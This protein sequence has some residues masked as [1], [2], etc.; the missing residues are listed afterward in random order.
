M[1]NVN[2]DIK[3]SKEIKWSYSRLSC[4]KQCHFQYKLKYVDKHFP[5]FGNVA[6][7]FGTA[8]HHAE[9]T[10]GNFIKDNQ[11]IN[12]VQ[13]KNQFILDCA[14]TS[15]K[16]KEWFQQNKDSGKTYEEQKY[17]YLKYGVYRLE[18]FM[19]NHPT[20]IIK[21]AEVPIDYYYKDKRFT[22]S[23]DRLLFDTATG[24]Y[25][26]Q[27]IKSWP[28]M[29]PK[30]TED[31][32]LPVQLAVYSL[33]LSEMVGCDLDHIKCQY[34]LPL[35]DNIYDAGEP[36]FIDV[37]KEH[38]DEWFAGIEAQDWH[39]VATALCAWCP[40]SATNPDSSKDFKYLCP[41]HSVW[42]RE[43]KAKGTSNKP[44]NHW[45]GIENHESI[46]ENYLRKEVK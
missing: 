41:Y 7:E 10:I 22:G 14:K 40:F 30:H 5:P 29:E 25:Y 24:I 28:V 4:Y 45:A 6:T 43:L 16:Y 2:N 20:Y 33:A 37:T 38:L 26:I 1:Q 36:G 42:D 19:K 23:I 3:K 15:F 18:N 12:Y 39:P 9:E 44:A 35:V 17:Y 21:G 46:M 27:D 32:K 8:I 31:K 13:V 11:P 34:D